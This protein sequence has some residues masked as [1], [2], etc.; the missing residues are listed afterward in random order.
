APEIDQ[1]PDGHRIV[2][3]VSTD[4]GTA[5]GGQ[6]GHNLPVKG[7]EVVAHEH[8]VGPYPASGRQHLGD[9][10]AARQDL[11]AA[12]SGQEA[13]DEG[14]LPWRGTRSTDQ[15]GG[16]HPP[17]P[18]LADAVVVTAPRSS[19]STALSGPGVPPSARTMS[20]LALRAAN[21]SSEATFPSQA[22]VTA[23]TA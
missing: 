11:N 17:T 19:N 5:G 2:R 14:C 7:F 4:D 23:D 6:A 15:G 13:T 16:L 20:T 12:V 8:D 18:P 1:P 21:T 22:T 9:V 3:R 10:E